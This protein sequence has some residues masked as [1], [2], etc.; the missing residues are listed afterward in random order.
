MRN[1]TPGRPAIGPK[2]PINFP[3]DLLKN[4]EAGAS[5]ARLS[6]A[7]WVRRAVAGALPENFEGTLTPDDMLAYLT[8]SLRGADPDHEVDSDTS[9]RLLTAADDGTLTIESSTT[10]TVTM[11]DV[12]SR[13]RLSFITRKFLADRADIT[14]YQVGYSTITYQRWDESDGDWHREHTLYLDQDAAR[15]F[16]AGL[17]RDV[18]HTPDAS[19]LS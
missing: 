8:T 15:T 9:R 4:I 3:T 19:P 1:T 12:R 16:H 17:R 6:R 7:A 5:L 11:E 2:V 13:R 18:I 14:V 10:E